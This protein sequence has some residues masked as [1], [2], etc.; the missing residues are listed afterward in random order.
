MR[1]SSG[2]DEGSTDVD[3][4]VEIITKDRAEEAQ[5]AVQRLL[6]LPERVPII[7]V[8]NGSTQ[9]R[10]GVLERLARVTCRLI[11]NCSGASIPCWSK[12]SRPPSP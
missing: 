2:P 6:A 12:A 5:R 8:D 9:H 3:I 7:V 10:M 4:T 1:A 11:E